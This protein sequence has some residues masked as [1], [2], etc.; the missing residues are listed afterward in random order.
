MQRRRV[1]GGV[2]IAALMLILQMSEVA[3][4]GAWHA[5]AAETCGAEHDAAICQWT[6]FVHAPVGIM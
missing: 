5:K 3:S 4:A 1:L 2:C 6:P